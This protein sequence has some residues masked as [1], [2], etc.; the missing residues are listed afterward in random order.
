MNLPSEI[1]TAPFATPVERKR[2]VAAVIE[3]KQRLLICL[4]PLEKQH[5]GLW[6]FPGGKIHDHESLEGAVT[7]EL[8]EELGVT[9]TSVGEVLFSTFDRRSGFEILFLPTNI[10]GEPQPLEHLALTWCARSDLLSYALA[11]SDHA[12]ASFLLREG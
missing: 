4:R 7:R 12:F 5:G 3:R 10:D 6:E 8:T 1:P 2:V 9:A 11:P